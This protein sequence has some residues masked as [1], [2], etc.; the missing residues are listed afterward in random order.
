[1]SEEQKKWDIYYSKPKDEPLPDDEQSY[2]EDIPI[3]RFARPEAE[4][5][6]ETPYTND[7]EGDLGDGGG[8]SN[9]FSRFWL[10]K[11]KRNLKLFLGIFLGLVLVF[12]GAIGVKLGLDWYRKLNR[13]EYTDGLNFANADQ[14][15][16]SEEEEDPTFTPMHDV[17]DASSL[18]DWLKKWATNGGEKMQTKNVINCLLCGVDTEEGSDGRTDAMILVS[19]NKKTKK[20]TLVSF[21]RDSYTYMNIDGQ[22]RWYK[23]NASHNWGGPAT[24]METIEN[25]YKVEIDHFI[26]VDF[27]SFPK[28]I[29]ALG[30]VEI[31]VEEY[32][33]R[34]IRRT[35]S[36]KHFPYGKNVK[37]N[38]DQA[39]IY[40][41]IRKSDADGDLSRTRRQ[42]KLVTALMGKAKTASVGQLNNMLDLVLP[43]VATNYRPA[44]LLSLGSQA[45]MQKWMNYEIEQMSCPLLD[46]NEDGSVDLTGKDSYMMTGYGY[47]AEFVWIVDYQLDAQRVQ[48]ALY[49]TT[50]VEVNDYI[51]E[52]PFDFLTG[53][54]R[55][56]SYGQSS[57]N[58]NGAYNADP[59]AE[60]QPPDETPT[61]LIDRWLRLRGDRNDEDNEMPSEPQQFDDTPS[62]P[63]NAFAP[64]ADD[65]P[66]EVENAEPEYN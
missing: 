59:V 52:S 22:D 16:F 38:G 54:N 34:Y 20:I 48:K 47:A 21:M 15:E 28:L 4:A 49:G 7:Y 2:G 57:S 35:S 41:R 30:G 37:L 36:H 65:P 14:T 33:A 26:T 55:D 32:E 51:R 24:L 45:I 12:G 42:R 10:K 6:A 60:E 61:R 56:G 8:Y 23:I 13:I 31:D 64:D 50:N 3:S 63:L 11:K 9:A 18:K 43:F 40:S 29:D 19:V 46:V 62:D 66:V 1:M 39:L 53:S 5:E 27:T 17:A 25:N 44:Q 58:G